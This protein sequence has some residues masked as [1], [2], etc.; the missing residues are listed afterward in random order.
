MM[1]EEIYLNKVK[2]NKDE[3]NVILH[4]AYIYTLNILTKHI[5][6]L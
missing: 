4:T 1:L 2:F 3:N 5:R 6:K